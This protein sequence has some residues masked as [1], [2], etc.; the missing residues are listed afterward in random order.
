M[1]VH[2]LKRRRGRRKKDRSISLP[3]EYNIQRIKEPSSLFSPAAF[4][5]LSYNKRKGTITR[6]DWRSSLPP[7]PSPP[8]PQKKPRPGHMK[9]NAAEARKEKRNIFACWNSGRKGSF[10]RKQPRAH[11]EEKKK[12]V[13]LFF[14]SF[15][16]S[17]TVV[18]RSFWPA[19][20]WLV[21]CRLVYRSRRASL[22]LEGPFS[23]TRQWVPPFFF[24]TLP[25]HKERKKA[26]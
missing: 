26:S 23:H 8:P 24:P 2:S 19:V 5:G 22:F 7:P 3:S 10:P 1:Y 6:R 18:S 12:R 25:T 20:S 9:Q 15:S 11:E 21:V 4:I 14:L 13:G 17:L 16:F